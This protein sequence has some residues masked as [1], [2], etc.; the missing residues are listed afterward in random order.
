MPTLLKHTVFNELSNARNTN[1]MAILQV[2][3][4]IDKEVAP[5]S[6][7]LVSIL[8]VSGILKRKIRQIG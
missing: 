4:N 1:N 2:M 6:L 3:F 7:A 5:T 8:S